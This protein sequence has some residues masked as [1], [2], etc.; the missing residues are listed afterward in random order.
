MQ[1]KRVLYDSIILFEAAAAADPEYSQRV[2][3]RARKMSPN[4]L[5]AKN[6][7]GDEMV[8]VGRGGD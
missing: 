5:A 7:V 4:N 3:R 8:G 2:I 1:L 6:W